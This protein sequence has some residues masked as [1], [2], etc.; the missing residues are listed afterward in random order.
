M[1]AGIVSYSELG[2]KELKVG[3]RGNNGE[4]GGKTK[5]NIC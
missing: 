2:C 4:K 1:G 3:S 5:K